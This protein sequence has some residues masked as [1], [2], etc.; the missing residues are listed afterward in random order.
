M[1]TEV[2]ENIDSKKLRGGYYT[3]QPI[4]DFICKWAITNPTQKV[5]EPSCGDGNFIE[6]AI[7]RF[8]E[9]G[10]QDNQ[11]YGLIQGVELLE[12]EA[13]KSKKRAAKYGLN[14][15]TI[16]NDD[17]FNFILETNGNARYDV[18]IGNPPFIRY[19]NFPEE[20]RDL[21]IKMMQEMEL[22]PNK[23][24]NIWVP[25]LVISASKLRANGKL[26]MVIP[27]ELFQVK[28]AAETR[29]FLSNFFSRI[30]IVTFK[31]LVFSDIQQEVVL[32][33]C[34]KNVEENKGV[35]V[36][37][38]N[39]L[40]E[41]GALNLDQ[42]QN[43]E[44]KSLDHSTE[45]WTKYFLD[46]NEIQLLRRIKADERINPSFDVMDVDVGIVTGRN[47]FFMMNEE[48]VSQ[49]KLQPYTTRVVGKS[50]HLKG[51]V[52]DE[53]DFEANVAARYPVHLFLP[54]AKEY[55]KQP[56]AVKEY[57]SYGEEKEHHTG[58]KCKIRKLWYITPSLWSPDAFALRQV[59]EYPKLIVNNTGAS[60]TDT[61]H[62]VRFKNGANAEIVALSYLN[63]LTFAFSEIMGRSY[64][65]GVLTFEPSEIEELPLPILR[66]DHMINFEEIDALMRNRNIEEVLDII[67]NELLIN[68]LKFSRADVDTLRGIWKKLSNRRN[69][70]K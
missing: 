8:K 17:F 47:E 41:L 6:S 70:R 28:Y 21:A 15:D 50:A 52:Y 55:S 65:G 64:G 67:D 11:L 27:A 39:D 23:L 31:K 68:Q 10:V 4:A 38:V 30:T 5:L 45:K 26:G 69:N 59:G 42:I 2:T 35:R 7:K 66:E 60:S 54:E 40:K 56:K 19:Q 53:T 16:T 29:V 58:Y 9:L 1:S 13:E 24:T 37:E 14:S 46:E 51:I 63:S 25:F 32:L 18:V 62:R 48:T 36:I 43:I 12:V 22:R 61:I 20:H 44:V 33:L 34:E 3:P 57:I 49:W